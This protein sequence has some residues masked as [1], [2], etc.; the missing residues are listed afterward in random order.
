MSDSE[1]ITGIITLIPSPDGIGNL[2][3][4]Y[5]TAK[6]LAK[7]YR[8]KYV[9]RANNVRK[10]KLD[11]VYELKYLLENY[12]KNPNMIPGNI[13]MDG[14]CQIDQI[15]LDFPEIVELFN[16]NN[17]DQVQDDMRICDIYNKITKYKID[18][19][20]DDIVLHLRLNDFNHGQI[21][22]PE[23][24]IKLL[25][26]LKFKKLYIVLDKPKNKWEW[27]Y[28]GHFKKYN[29]IIDLNSN[30][31]SDVAKIYYAKRL[32]CSNSTMCWIFGALGKSVESYLPKVIKAPTFKS[33]Y[34]DYVSDDYI[35]H[36]YMLHQDFLKCKPESKNFDAEY[37]TK[38]YTN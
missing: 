3:F 24:Y 12:K 16:E 8:K 23:C 25:D 17:T 15:F 32:I 37:Q 7:L 10:F 26:T 27:E 20:D 31:Y 11:S 19:D 36:N 22:Q 35:H 13:Q 9:F 18:F 38:I 2:L 14:W 6:I 33:M 30:L 29:P 1:N 28:I 21:I 34:S 5:L 4:R